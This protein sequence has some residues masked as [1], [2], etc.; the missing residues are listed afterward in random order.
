MP[1][2]PSPIP[3]PSPN[4]NQEIDDANNFISSSFVKEIDQMLGTN[5]NVPVNFRTRACKYP[6]KKDSVG[7]DGRKNDLSYEKMVMA[8]DEKH[9]RKIVRIDDQ[10][11]KEKFSTWA[12]PIGALGDSQKGEGMQLVP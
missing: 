2:P 7:T 6:Y 12:E 10:F 4:K 8:M 11:K 3:S 1:Q 5:L 9:P